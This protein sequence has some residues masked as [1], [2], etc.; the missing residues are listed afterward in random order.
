MAG[1]QRL[2]RREE[3][4]K[5]AHVLL[6]IGPSALSLCF[7][8]FSLL[9]QSCSYSWSP[10][11]KQG[12]PTAPQALCHHQQ[13]ELCRQ[14]LQQWLKQQSEQRSCMQPCLTAL[15]PWSVPLLPGSH[16]RHLTGTHGTN[17]PSRKF[18]WPKD[19]EGFH[20]LV[21]TGGNIPPHPKTPRHNPSRNTAST[22]PSQG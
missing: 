19:A 8:S 12:C 17:R 15:P 1:R 21:G 14:Q 2:Q 7:P 10:L 4:F 6:G 9:L 5:P 13:K 3:R 11:P 16:G 22:K 20:Q 18:P